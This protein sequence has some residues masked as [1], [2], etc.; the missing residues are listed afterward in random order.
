MKSSQFNFIIIVIT[1]ISLLI[2]SN[3]VYSTIHC[4]NTSN[5]FS[6]LEN[7]NNKRQ[8]FCQNLK[9]DILNAK[10]TGNQQLLEEKES[11]AKYFQCPSSK[12]PNFAGYI[13]HMLD[14]AKTNKLKVKQ[15]KEEIKSYFNKL[16]FNEIKVF[17][18]EEKAFHVA[19][20]KK[21]IELMSGDEWTEEELQTGLSTFYKSELPEMLEFFSL[22][23]N[24]GFKIVKDA[25]ADVLYDT[26]DNTLKFNQFSK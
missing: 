3:Q 14:I 10:S 5:D 8:W 15:V 2:Y 11:L 23:K 13:Q 22:D 26:T 17:E 7:T 18:T 21:M 12:Y 20:E 1:M 24:S 25:M 9:K 4:G 16:T 6:N 19:L